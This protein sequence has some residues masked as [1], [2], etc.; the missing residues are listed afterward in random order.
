[1]NLVSKGFVVMAIDPVAQGERLEYAAPSGGMD[2]SM[3]NTRGHAYVGAQLFLT[4]ESLAAA[5]IW[6]GM[7]AIDY[8]SERP[9]VDA[10]RIAVTGRSGAGTQ[11]AYLGAVDDRVAAVAIENYI[12]SFRRLWETRGPQDAEQHFIRGIARGLDHGDLLI[13]R[14]PRPTLL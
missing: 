1:L 5:M 8:L 13:A 9:E 2:A 12:T 6:D 11:S 14:A 7:R 4:G 3:S 10:A